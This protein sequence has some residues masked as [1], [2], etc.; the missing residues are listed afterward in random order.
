MAGYNGKADAAT[1]TVFDHGGIESSIQLLATVTYNVN[2]D[3][4]NHSY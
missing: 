4:N 1:I 2:D 3:H